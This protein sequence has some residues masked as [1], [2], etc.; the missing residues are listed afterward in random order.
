[1][2][3]LKKTILLVEDDLLVTRSQTKLLVKAGF[4]VVTASN[5]NDAIAKAISGTPGIDLILMDIDLGAGIDG[6]EAAKI[7]LRARKI[8]LIFLSSHRE[9]DMVKKAETVESYGYVVKSSGFA[10]LDAAIRRALDI[11]GTPRGPRKAA[12]GPKKELEMH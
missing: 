2:G 9:S 1:M 11:H 10:Q 12:Q 8:P 5:G 7:I 6:T 3:T 4:N